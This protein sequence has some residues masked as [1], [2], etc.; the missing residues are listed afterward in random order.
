MK[1]RHLIIFITPI[2]LFSFI[3]HELMLKIV[4]IIIAIPYDEKLNGYS[5]SELVEGTGPMKPGNLLHSAALV[6][7]LKQGS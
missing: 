3:Y 4:D 7:N 6:P 5:Y 2:G 1:N